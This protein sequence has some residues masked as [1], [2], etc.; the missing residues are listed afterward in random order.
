MPG[1]ALVLGAGGTVGHAFH[2]G[3]L[4]AL[5]E[6]CGWD[7]R[8]ADVVVGTSAGSVVAALL[9]A[10]MPPADLVRAGQP[11]AAVARRVRRSSAG[12]GSG[13]PAR[14]AAPAAGGLD[15][16]AGPAA[17]APCGPRGR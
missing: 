12:P 8:R 13:R 3:V 2:A 11:A 17:P 7:A 9:R 10:G 4:T 1:I 14:A 5:A 16:L 6:V 15:G